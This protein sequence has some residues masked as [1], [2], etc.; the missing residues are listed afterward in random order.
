MH[1]YCFYYSLSVLYQ[2]HLS[3]AFHISFHWQFA[4]TT[5]GIRRGISGSLGSNVRFT[6]NPRTK[7]INH[8]FH[9]TRLSWPSA[10]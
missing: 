5:C 8:H 10:R 2:S 4:A 9:A 3:G 7:S 6:L 1:I